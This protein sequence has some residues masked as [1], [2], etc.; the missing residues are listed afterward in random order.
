MLNGNSFKIFIEYAFSTSLIPL[1]IPINLIV[2]FLFCL[3]FVNIFFDTQQQPND[4]RLRAP[5]RRKQTNKA[6]KLAKS[7]LN[8]EDLVFG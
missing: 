1:I 2:H 3:N 6:E 8:A 5:S 4:G 7:S